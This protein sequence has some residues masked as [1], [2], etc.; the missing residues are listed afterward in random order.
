MS[1]PARHGKTVHYASSGLPAPFGRGLDQRSQRLIS[2]QDD[3]DLR[4]PPPNCGCLFCGA[5]LP[6]ATVT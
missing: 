3:E 6:K 2:D 1:V 5:F 4:H